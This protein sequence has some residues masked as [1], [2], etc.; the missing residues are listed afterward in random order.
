MGDS[1]ITLAIAMSA[2]IVILRRVDS[3]SLRLL[4]QATLETCSGRVTL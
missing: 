2:L 3:I 4:L 1:D